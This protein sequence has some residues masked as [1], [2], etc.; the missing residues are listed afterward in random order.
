MTA[1]SAPVARRFGHQVRQGSP[2]TRKH[3]RQTKEVQFSI[4]EI[5]K[6][7]AKNGSALK[8]LGIGCGVFSRLD[9]TSHASETTPVRLSIY[10]SQDVSPC[11]WQ[12]LDR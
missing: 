6:Q 12:A 10:T 11:H 3:L 9:V 5:E 1:V 4:N 8:I 2:S 7:R